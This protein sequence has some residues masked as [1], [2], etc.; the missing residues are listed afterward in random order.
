MKVILVPIAERPECSIAL[1]VAFKLA[2]AHE[3][4]VVGC[5]IRPHR[6][7]GITITAS[8]LSGACE[9]DW[10]ESTRGEDAKRVSANARSFFARLAE[11]NDIPLVARP[12]KKPGATA[13]W[14]ERVGSPSRIIPIVGPVSDLLVVS[15]PANKKSGKIARIFLLE[16]LLHSSRPVLILPQKQHK[17]LGKR[18]MIAWN[19]SLEAMR[20]VAATLPML[21][22]AEAVTIV[23]AGPE[24]ALGPKSRQL[25]GYLKC[26]GVDADILRTKG[27][28]EASEIMKVYR[29]TRSDLLVMG[30][31]S[32]S[33]LRELVFGGM[34]DF[35]LYDANVPVLMHHT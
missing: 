21:Q 35:M 30:A 32:R 16:A 12:R 34:T 6:E 7:S 2:E 15:R 14:S 28:N 9:A 25:A 8:A 17:T 18:V 5:H 29:E 31:Y 4:C 27:S 10:I 24:A 20:S 33:R 11:C 1:T 19:Q 23:A 26:W 3:A 13:I 22:Q